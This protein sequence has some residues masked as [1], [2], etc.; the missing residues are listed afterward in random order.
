M[1]TIPYESQPRYDGKPDPVECL[2]Q[3]RRMPR[4]FVESVLKNPDVFVDALTILISS[5]DS[6]NETEK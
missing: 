6:T 1:S 2:I 3:G 4:K 5:I